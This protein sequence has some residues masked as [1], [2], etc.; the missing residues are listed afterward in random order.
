MTKVNLLI[1]DVARIRH[2]IWSKY[3]EHWY[4]GLRQSVLERLQ[5]EELL[6]P[7]SVQG[8]IIRWFMA[9]DRIQELD[10]LYKEVSQIEQHILTQHHDQVHGRTYE[11]MQSQ[12][13]VE[14]LDRRQ[15]FVVAAD[16]LCQRYGIS[17][18]SAELLLANSHDPQKQQHILSGALKLNGDLAESI[19]QVAMRELPPE[20][21]QSIALQSQQI[22]LEH[23]Y[24]EMSQETTNERI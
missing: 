20:R 3:A 13:S 6:Y 11:E 2:A 22:A 15:M 8:K 14:A 19:I 21:R 12:Y 18:S 9:Q 24:L 5:L 10:L 4:A 17:Q 23:R 1:N 7:K 16:M